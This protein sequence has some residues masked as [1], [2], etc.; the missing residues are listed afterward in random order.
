V[1]PPAAGDKWV[2]LGNFC[3]RYH[4]VAPTGGGTGPVAPTGGGTEP[5]APTRGG[6][7]PVAPTGGGTGPWL[8]NCDLEP[9]R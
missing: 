6:T 2:A 7:G 9:T 4:S 3:D 8:R 5:V 1:E